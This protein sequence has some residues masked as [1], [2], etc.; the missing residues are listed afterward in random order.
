MKTLRKKQEV[1]PK[2]GS[3]DFINDMGT[4]E[5]WSRLQSPSLV[6][7]SSGNVCITGN[8]NKNNGNN[9]NGQ[10][11]KVP[12]PEELSPKSVKKQSMRRLQTMIERNRHLAP[13]LRSSYV[14]EG[15]DGLDSEICDE[16]HVDPE[17][18]H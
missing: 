9:S 6:S 2:V 14:V 13:H 7:V 12:L 11:Q 10:Q 15:L 16:S 17:R 5:G 18:A 4:E 3:P 8:S 1:T